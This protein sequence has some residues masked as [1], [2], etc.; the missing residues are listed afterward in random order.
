[1]GLQNDFHKVLYDDLRER[2][3]ETTADSKVKL[4]TANQDDCG[5]HC[6]LEELV[7]KDSMNDLTSDQASVASKGPND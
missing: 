7:V 4:R 3:N 2:V 1:M 6:S 5:L